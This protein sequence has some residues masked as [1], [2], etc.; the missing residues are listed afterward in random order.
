M[1]IFQFLGTEIFYADSMTETEQFGIQLRWKVKFLWFFS[2]FVK[3]YNVFFLICY[4]VFVFSR[5]EG[6]NAEIQTLSVW[7]RFVHKTS[8]TSSVT[9]Q[10]TFSFDFLDFLLVIFRNC[11][12]GATVKKKKKKKKKEKYLE[13]LQRPLKHKTVTGLRISHEFSSVLSDISQPIYIVI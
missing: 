9:S 4:Y 8:H 7:M 6:E 13:V 12:L 5:D 11:T 2:P 10:N 1:L 3:E